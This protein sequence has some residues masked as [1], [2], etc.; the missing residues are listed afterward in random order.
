M[1]QPSSPNAMAIHPEASLTPGEKIVLEG[2]GLG[3]IYGRG[4]RS[5][6]VF[7][8]VNLQLRQGE[9]VAIVAPS[10]A[11]KSTLLHLLASLDTP[12]SGAIYFDSKQ[13]ETNDEAAL[14]SFRIAPWGFCGKAPA[15]SGFYGG[16][17]CS[18]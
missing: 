15:A 3:K 7:Q 12:T 2:R 6:N 11:G 1:N 9:M 17:E 18:D 4:E 14:S 16:R 5:L 10:G 13:L 8:Q